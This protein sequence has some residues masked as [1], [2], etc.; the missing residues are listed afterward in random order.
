MRG[1]E[2]ATSAVF[3]LM[4][5]RGRASQCFWLDKSCRS[6]NAGVFKQTFRFASP[7]SPSASA[8]ALVSTSV[9]A[10]ASLPAGP[11]LKEFLPPQK[12]R[13]M[14]PPPPR[15]AIPGVSHIV[16]VSSGKGG[17]G[18]STVAGKAKKEF[19]FDGR[20]GRKSKGLLPFS[21]LSQTSSPRRRR[22]NNPRLLSVWGPN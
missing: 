20:G 19:C 8:S 15:Q 1:S 11:G 18:K 6:R 7:F 2:A 5:R 9:S 16:A 4:L 14:P 10:W 12:K 13:P 21:F 17:V 3:S 22:R